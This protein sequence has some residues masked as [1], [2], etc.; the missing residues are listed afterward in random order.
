[1]AGLCLGTAQLGMQYGINNKVG[2]LRR[3]EVFDI[4]N[5]AINAGICMIDTASIYG[6]AE[7]LLGQYLSEHKDTC[8]DI[9]IITKQCETINGKTFDQIEGE[10]RKELEQSLQRLQCD[11]LDG[12]LLHLYREID[13]KD[14]MAVLQKLKEEG[15]VKNVGVSVYDVDEAEIAL[16]SGNVDYLQMPCSVFD[17]RGLTSG[18]FE[19]AKEKGVTVFTRSA[20]LQ[21]LLMMK[22][23]EVPSG[24]REIIPYLEKFEELLQKYKIEKRH[25]VIKFILDEVSIDYMVFGVEK[26]RQLEE[27]IKEMKAKPLN[28]KFV[29]EIKENF[30]N[31]SSKLILPIHWK[32]R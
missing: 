7:E 16:E 32:V 30:C 1:M 5:T 29:K 19:K 17:Q 6:E 15:I 11:S 8:R 31:M 27:I 10:I 26:R 9:R 25:A 4:L 22:I 13:N 21:G 20:F 2:K 18:V 28:E 24:L 14:T 23:E 3:E 12:Y